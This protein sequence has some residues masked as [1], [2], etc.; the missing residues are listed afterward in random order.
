MLGEVTLQ[1]QHPDFHGRFP[2]VVALAVIASIG[3]GDGR[4]LLM[5]DQVG[6]VRSHQPRT[7]NLSASGISETPIPT[8][9]SPNPL[10]TSARILGSL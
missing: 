6:W 8:M 2:I 5:D 3:G 7:A 1:G 9:A 10:L 4:A